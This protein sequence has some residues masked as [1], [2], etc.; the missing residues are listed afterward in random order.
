MRNSIDSQYI[1]KKIS[2]NEKENLIKMYN[3]YHKLYTCYKWKYKRLKKVK[4]AL[5]M[6]SIGLTVTGT[7]VG[8]VTL[9]PVIIG[10]LTG[11]GVLVQ[12]YVSKSNLS[13][14]VEDC[15]FAYTSY[16]KVLTQLRSYL[17]GLPYD[18]QILLS[19]LKVLDDIVTDSCPTVN[20]MGDRYDK[21]YSNI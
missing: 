2:I 21:K 12:G 4:L 18:N 8:S 15:R 9:N 16:Q 5:D 10:C 14:K 13:N 19:D 7:I 3:S 11:S 17:R 20:G 1:S 6:V